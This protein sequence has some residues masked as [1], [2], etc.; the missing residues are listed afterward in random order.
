[1]FANALEYLKKEYPN[2][3]KFTVYDIMHSGAEGGVYKILKIIKDQMID[4]AF[5]KG[6]NNFVNEYLRN[7]NY[8]GRDAAV[9]EYL[10]EV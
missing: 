10:E 8:E 5:S 7:L 3:T 4:D 2:N 6:I 9:K 1:M